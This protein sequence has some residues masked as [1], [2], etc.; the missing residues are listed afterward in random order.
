MSMLCITLSLSFHDLQANGYPL[1]TLYCGYAC[2]ILD[3]NP[4]QKAVLTGQID[5][6]V[7][8]LVIYCFD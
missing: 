3:V 6:G 4:E 8:M 1:K 2:H 7:K 5:G